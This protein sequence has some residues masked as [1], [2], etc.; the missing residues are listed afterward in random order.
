MKR[1]SPRVKRDHQLKSLLAAL[2]EVKRGD[3]DDGAQ[4]L[5]GARRPAS[6]RE[7]KLREEQMR[8]E[9]ER[10]QQ[11]REKKDP[12]KASEASEKEELK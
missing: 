12:P 9:H 11:K 3:Q 5:E 8:R 10:T 7:Q 4:V 6:R 1:K 2:D